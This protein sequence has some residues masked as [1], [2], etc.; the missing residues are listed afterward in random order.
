M[1]KP[2]ES[3]QKWRSSD[4]TALTIK[5]KKWM[6]EKEV[7]ENSKL[8]FIPESIT[9][10]GHTVTVSPDGGTAKFKRFDGTRDKELLNTE[11][12]V[13]GMMK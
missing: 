2:D 6:E 11:A 5:L 10:S 9:F 8:C 3:W 13:K 1:K 4:K 12:D 7:Y